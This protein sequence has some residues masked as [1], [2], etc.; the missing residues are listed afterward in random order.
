MIHVIATIE[1]Q[2]GTRQEFLRHV[3]AILPAV[4]AEEGCLEYGPAVDL[5]TD[6]ANQSP[7]RDDVVAMIEKWEDLPAL[8]A[9][10]AAP[11]MAEYR[12]KVRSMVVR[13]Q[14]QILQPA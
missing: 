7:P 11:H 9:H 1:L 3:Q 8:R 4:R 13:T 10:L 6:L 14:L 2:P 5:P 12:Q